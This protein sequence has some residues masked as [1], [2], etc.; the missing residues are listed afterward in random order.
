MSLLRFSQFTTASGI[1]V[2]PMRRKHFRSCDLCGATVHLDALVTHAR[3]HGR[4]GD[5][6]DYRVDPGVC[7]NHGDRVVR[8]DDNLA[9]VAAS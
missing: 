4:R 6:D 7:E 9:E 8:F 5:L 1:L 3:F 2:G